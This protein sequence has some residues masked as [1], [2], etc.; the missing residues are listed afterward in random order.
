MVYA[1]GLAGPCRLD[2]A[3]TYLASTGT[4]ESDL[5]STCLT[6]FT[7]VEGFV[8]EFGW[9]EIARQAIDDLEKLKEGLR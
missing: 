9:L 4:L 1:L 6:A 2:A 7:L 5:P 3:R 8:T